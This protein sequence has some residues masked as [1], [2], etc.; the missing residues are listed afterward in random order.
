MMRKKTTITTPITW[1]TSKIL[2]FPLK[3]LAFPSRLQLTIICSASSLFFVVPTTVM[4]RWGIGEEDGSYG[5]QLQLLVSHDVKGFF[6][7]GRVEASPGDRALHEA[8]L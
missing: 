3:A 6:N 4:S 1:T 8:S 5:L 7:G 2:D